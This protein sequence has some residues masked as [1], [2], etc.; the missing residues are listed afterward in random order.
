MA[1]IQATTGEG[2]RAKARAV[3]IALDAFPEAVHAN[4][5]VTFTDRSAGVGIR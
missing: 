2:F 4:K 3:T 1:G 5:I